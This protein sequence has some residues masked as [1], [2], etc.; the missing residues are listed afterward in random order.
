MVRKTRNRPG[1]RLLNQL[2][3]PIHVERRVRPCGDFMNHSHEHNDRC[4]LPLEELQ[5]KLKHNSNKITGPRVAILEALYSQPHPIAI[6]QIFE[7]VRDQ[8]CDLATVYRSMHLLEELG[9]VTRYDFGDG[10]ARFELAC[11]GHHHHHHHLVCNQCSNVVELDECLAEEWQQKLER[12]TGFK[13]V[14]HRLEFFGIC[15]SCQ[16][17]GAT[18]RKR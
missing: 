10:S 4:R 17:P 7:L 9:V 18:A 13:A 6:K 11:E 15:P 5:R 2:R 8:G 12:K 1:F 16:K 3:D 14:S